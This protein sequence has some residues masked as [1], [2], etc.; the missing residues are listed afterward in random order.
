MVVEPVGIYTVNASLAGYNPNFESGVDATLSPDIRI[1]LS[2]DDTDGDGLSDAFEIAIGTDPALADSDGDGL[3]DGIEVGFDGNF[4]DYNPYNP[5][6]QTGTDLNATP[7]AVDGIDGFD[8]DGDGLDDATEF[9][10]TTG[11]EPID[12]AGYPR[13]ADGDLAPLGDPDGNTNA[14]D[15]LVASRIALGLVTASVLELAHGDMDDDGVIGVAD[16]ILIMQAIQ[17]AP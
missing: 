12:P 8:S 3:D 14:A 1:D 9:N 13:L 6:T 7:A 15:Y 2:A 17:A 4:A 10:N 16:L 5:V 11:S